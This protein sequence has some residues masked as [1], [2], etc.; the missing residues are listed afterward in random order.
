MEVKLGN[1]NERKIA[2]EDFKRVYDVWHDFVSGKLRCEHLREMT[3]HATYI[4]GIF[5]HLGM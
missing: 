4:I 5:R 2:K 1:G 3:P